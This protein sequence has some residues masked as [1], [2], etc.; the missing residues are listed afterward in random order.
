MAG[1]DDYTNE[2]RTLLYSRIARAHTHQ[3]AAIPFHFYFIPVAKRGE[4]THAR[5]PVHVTPSERR[6]N[7]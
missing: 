3:A 5:A 4:V 1:T 2:Q 7:A 6:D